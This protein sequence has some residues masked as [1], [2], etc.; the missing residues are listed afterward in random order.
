MAEMYESGDSLLSFEHPPSTHVP[1]P[2]PCTPRSFGSRIQS[3]GPRFRDRRRGARNYSA[4]FKDPGRGR[5][6][7][8]PKRASRGTA[9]PAIPQHSVRDA[10]DWHTARAGG[11]QPHC[12]RR[13]PRPPLPQPRP[14]RSAPGP[15]PP[16]GRPAVRR[17]RETPRRGDPLGAPGTRPESGA[18][19]SPARG[20]GGA[21]A[22]GG[23]ALPSPPLPTPSP[24]APYPRGAAAAPRRPPAHV[25]PGWLSAAGSGA[26]TPRRRLAALWP[27]LPARA[28]RSHSAAVGAVADA[29]LYSKWRGRDVDA[30]RPT[31][32]ARPIG[33]VRRLK[34]RCRGSGAGAGSTGVARPGGA[35]AFVSE[36]EDSGPR[37]PPRL[38]SAQLERQLPSLPRSP[39]IELFCER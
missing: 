9:G 37:R 18:A 20:P 2:E 16:P 11:A 1:N 19:R 13:T 27:P 21:G 31:S 29:A 26:R 14:P 4:G 22:W 7:P 38:C 10:T 35:A 28:P 25:R 8:S 17:S 30:R 36:G 33:A 5:Q 3:K 6:P 39:D 34:G 24:Q 15:A 23:T 12:G 32:P